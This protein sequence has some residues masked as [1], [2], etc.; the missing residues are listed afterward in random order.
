[1]EDQREQLT[2][3]LTSMGLCSR[4]CLQTRRSFPVLTLGAGGFPEIALTGNAQLD[5]VL[6]SHVWTSGD[7]SAA[8]VPIHD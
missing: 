4:L 3:A 1:M 8:A 6:D 2:L 5:D 7:S